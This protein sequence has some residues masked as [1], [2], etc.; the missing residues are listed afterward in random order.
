[1]RKAKF[2]CVYCKDIF[3]ENDNEPIEELCFDCYEQLSQ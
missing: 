1:M 3:M 2:Q